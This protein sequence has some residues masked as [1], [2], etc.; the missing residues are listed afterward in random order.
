MGGQ[1]RCALAHLP[2]LAGRSYEAAALIAVP[3]IQPGSCSR[4]SHVGLA[5]ESRSSMM[6]DWCCELGVLALST[7]PCTAATET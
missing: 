3:K 6:V 5:S 4:P 2:L 7:R 1:E